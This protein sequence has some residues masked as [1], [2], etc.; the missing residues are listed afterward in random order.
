MMSY[1]CMLCTTTTGFGLAF[2]ADVFCCT[3]DSRRSGFTASLHQMF[4]AC[5]S[6]PQ[7]ISTTAVQI[8]HTEHSLPTRLSCTG[9]TQPYRGFCPRSISVS[10]C[11]LFSRSVLSYITRSVEAYV[12]QPDSDHEVRQ[13]TEP[14]RVELHVLASIAYMF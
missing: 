13:Q 11:A 3:M 9:L 2:C 1:C 8:E 5:A 14:A 12:A 4:C 10:Y 6:G 7:I